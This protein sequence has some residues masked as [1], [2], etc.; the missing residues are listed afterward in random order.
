MGG[1]EL[2]PLAQPAP[3]SYWPEHNPALDHTLAAKPSLGELIDRWY[4]ITRVLLEPIADRDGPGLARLFAHKFITAAAL[5]SL[6]EGIAFE[7]SLCLICIDE[8]CRIMRERV[9]LLIDPFAGSAERQT[10]AAFLKLKP[11]QQIF[12]LLYRYESH[13][14]RGELTAT[15]MQRLLDLPSEEAARQRAH[16][17]LDSYAQ[18]RRPDTREQL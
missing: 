16:R 9:R 17:A 13:G 2:T 3:G 10:A 6:A 8:L 11:E 7:R 12:I 18:L 4:P 14:Y 5:E 1:P 15:D